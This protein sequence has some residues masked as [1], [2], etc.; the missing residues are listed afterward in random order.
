MNFRQLISKEITHKMQEAVINEADK[1][2]QCHLESKEDLRQNISKV[3][4]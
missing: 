2:N 3:A 4:A 1:K